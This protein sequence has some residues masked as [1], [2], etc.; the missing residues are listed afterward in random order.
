MQPAPRNRI[1]HRID[2]GQVTQE[3][4]AIHARHF[5]ERQIE[6]ARYGVDAHAFT[7]KRSRVAHHKQSFVEVDLIGI[8]P[9]RF[10]AND[11]LAPHGG[12]VN[13]L[14]AGIGRHF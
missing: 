6:R 11:R 8:D 9:Q 4:G 1:A 12:D 13:K 2:L 3:I 7:R 5:H 10:H 14:R